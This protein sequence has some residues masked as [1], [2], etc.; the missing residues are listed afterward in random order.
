MNLKRFVYSLVLLVA[1]SPAMPAWPAATGWVDKDQVSVRLL[2][3]VD[4]IGPAGKT[5]P[6]GLQFKLKP[7]WK[8]YW[9]SPGDA[10]LP[11][12]LH[13]KDGGNVAS[14]RFLWPAP[15]RFS[16]LGLETLGY[17]DDVVLPL[18]ATLAEPGAADIRFRLDYLVC[19]EICVPHNSDFALALPA[20]PGTPSAEANLLARYRAQVPMRDRRHGLAIAAASF[21]AVEKGVDITLALK[22]E[23]ALS[24]PDVFFEGPLGSY[25]GKPAVTLS[26]DGKRAWLTVKAGG[27]KPDA[28]AKEGLV[29]TIVDGDRTLETDVPVDFNAAPVTPPKSAAPG[30]KTD[31]GAGAGK[32][33]SLGLILLF[34]LL[35]G[36]ILNV[37]P[38]VLP[39]LSIKLLGV[40][41]KSG[42]DR[43]AIRVGFLASAAGIVFSFLLIAGSLIAVK[44]AGMTVGWGI[45]FQQPV[46]LAFLAVVLGLFAYNLFGLY[47]ITLPGW[48][49]DI[50]IAGGHEKHLIG[51]FLTGAL[52]T[53]VATPCSAPF[54]G[55]AVGF[56]LSRGPAEILAVFTALG[57]GLAVPYLTVAAFPGL[58]Q[59]LP[60]PGAWMI[61]VRRVLGLALLLTVAW[62]LYVI[63][64]VI[65]MDG[66]FVLAAFLAVIG[67]VIWLRRMPASRLGRHAG[68]V[69][70]ALCLAAILF[71]ATWHRAPAP[72]LKAADQGYAALWQPFDQG[73]LKQLVSAGK[74]VL[75]DVT[76]DWCVT[77]QVNKRL[78]LQAGAVG[79][80][81]RSGK[82]VAMRADWTRP[83]AEIAAYLASFGRYGIPF[84]AVYGP[85]SPN[86][87]ALPELLTESLVLDAIAA[88][89]DKAVAA[90]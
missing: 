22:S 6:L 80:A 11:P 65:G 19:A 60:R 48:L 26:Q 40:I 43:A 50:A 85:K 5:V 46:F 86:G 25:F 82:L 28:F 35:G 54:L 79:A 44:S 37:M 76:A 78:V 73:R 14:A 47:E 58:A 81:I 38:C 89:S 39:V 8:I 36:M 3:A 51:H 53:L 12:K 62:L 68:K 21:A 67:A 87:I 64:N 29:A 34:A 4:S 20:G 88:A 61:W 72:V 18:D 83:N 63:A 74:T 84:N 15:K 66:A 31:T 45:Q 55:T 42:A 2:S 75:V 70:A 41:G 33:A 1:V 49:A 56:A 71:P 57:I 77:C 69:A 30:G 23:M 13:L 17:K 24:K 32:S 16:V 52:A 7:G 10:G 59:R 90:R 27:A 9:R